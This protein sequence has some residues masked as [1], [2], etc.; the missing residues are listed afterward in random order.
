M[1]VKLTTGFVLLLLLIIFIIQNTEVVNIKFI[2]WE[3][4]LSRVLMIFLVFLSGGVV[5]WVAN[6][7]Y[8]SHRN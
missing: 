8:R 7:V 3:M 5:G 2:F 6:T 1:N 4:S